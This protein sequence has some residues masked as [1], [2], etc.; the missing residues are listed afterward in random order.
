MALT[1]EFQHTY[2]FGNLYLLYPYRSS[3]YGFSTIHNDYLMFLYEYQGKV[4]KNNGQVM[5]SL[6]PGNNTSHSLSLLEGLQLATGA[7]VGLNV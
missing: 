3:L 2:Q 1:D 6:P 4:Q 5:Q 7:E